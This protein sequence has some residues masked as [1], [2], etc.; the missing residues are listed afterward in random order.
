MTE[1]IQKKTW[2]QKVAE[3]ALKQAAKGASAKLADFSRGKTSPSSAPTGRKRGAK[4]Q[5]EPEEVP[6]PVFDVMEGMLGKV[7]PN[8]PAAEAEAEAAEGVKTPPM[9]EDTKLMLALNRLGSIATSLEE[10]D[11]HQMVSDIS[12]L[13]KNADELPDEWVSFLY[14]RKV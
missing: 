2:K 6:N 11:T 14:G 13:L 4:V 3:E 12:L 1:P 9:S 5:P 10:E 8:S 7:F